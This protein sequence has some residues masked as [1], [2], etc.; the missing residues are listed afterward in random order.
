MNIELFPLI[1]FVVITTFTPGPNNISSA[2]MGVTYGYR[3]TV[4]FLLGIASGFF[5]VMICCAYLSSTILEIIPASEKYLRWVGALYIVWLAIGILRSSNS[6]TDT[7]EAPKAFIKGF[8][9]QLFNP[10]VAVYGLTI[11]STFLASIS[12]QINTLT[13]FA[14]ILALTAFAATSTWA[15]CGSV[16]KSKLKN[17]SFR[18]RINQLLSLLLIYTAVD[19]SGI[20]SPL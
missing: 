5:V 4:T 12:N 11:F 3:K 6:F 15:L 16:I 18:K 8:I 17:E 10:K 9:L 7:K 19:L 13:V 1:S 14:I 2:S 20:I